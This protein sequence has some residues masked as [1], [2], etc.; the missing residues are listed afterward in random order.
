[1]AESGGW[2]TI[3]SDAGVFTYLIEN[4]GVE[5]VQFEELMTLE[6]DDLKQISPIYGVIFLFKYNQG[7][8]SQGPIDGQ[9]DRNAPNHM[10]FANQ[11]IQNACATQAIL[12]VLLN[13][14]KEQVDIGGSLREF[15][16]FTD[17]FPPDLRGEAL[18]N[19]DLIRDVHNS[20]SRSNPFVDEGTRKATEEDDL[21]HFI[22]Y[23]PVNGVLYEIDGLQ[24]AP[25]SHGPCT[26]DEF[27]DKVIPVIQRRINRY[28]AGEIRFNLMAA[29]QD[30]RIKAVEIG[31]E[32]MLAREEQ[33]RK[34]W[35]TENELRRHNFVGFTYELLK[36]VVKEKVRDGTYDDWI[37]QTKAA[38]LQKAAAAKKSEPED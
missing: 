4:L 30:L 21:Y 38:N 5:N 6:A 10:F 2:H 14:D 26:Q 1:M 23:T 17:G 13:A 8:T 35:E 11:T 7:D 19:S 29:V 28:N 12:S 34:E 25:I 27:C 9:L 37:K 33:K 16:E 20:F 22:A 31:D 18:S 3:E 32:Q 24:P 36:G 15:K